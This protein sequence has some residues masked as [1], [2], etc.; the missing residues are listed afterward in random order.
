MSRG[1]GRIERIITEALLANP[2]AIFTVPDLVVLAYPDAPEIMRIRPHRWQRYVERRDFEKRHRSAILRAAKKAIPRAG[3]DVMKA[4]APGGPPVFFNPCDLASYNHARRRADRWYFDQ[5]GRLAE[6][7]ANPDEH[8]RAL[9]APGTGVW[10]QF[11]EAA[12]LRRDGRAVEAEA[13]DR[14]REQDS[15]ALLEGL[16]RR[17]SGRDFP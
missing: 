14:Q 4:E 16:E 12:K 9:L 10:W 3:W 7:L 2:S 13:I 17:I 15:A 8:H 5:P 1:P 6:H 11:V